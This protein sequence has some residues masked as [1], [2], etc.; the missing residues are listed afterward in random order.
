MY[1]YVFVKSS[2]VESWQELLLI[3]LLSDLRYGYSRL[4][5]ISSHSA[6]E[7]TTTSAR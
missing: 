5:P 6:D 3:A 1:L 7:V 4:W 2:L